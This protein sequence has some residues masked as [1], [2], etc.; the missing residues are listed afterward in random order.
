ML[1]ALAVGAAS[2]V[3][4]ADV[5]PLVAEATI[6][7][8]STRGRIDHIAVD[9][10]R[11]RLFVAELGNDT[12]DVV[13]LAK[14]AVVHRIKGLKEPQGVGYAPQAGVLAIA[15]AGDGSVHL[16]KGED[17]T[18]LGVARLGDERTISDW[19]QQPGNSWSAMGA[20]GWRHWIRPPSP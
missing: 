13:D 11:N 17:L 14:K 1:L 7:L 5:P 10:R 9:L 20:A 12:V 15:I 19:S 4:A 3:A 18:P 2:P 8:P 6:P 16:F